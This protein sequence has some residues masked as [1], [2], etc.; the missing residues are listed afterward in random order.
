MAHRVLPA[1]G[2]AR[3]VREVLQD[4]SID[5]LHRQR[6]AGR[7]F[8]GHV[9]EQ[10]EGER[11]LGL[12]GVSGV[13]RGRGDDGGAVVALDV[14]ERAGAGLGLGAA[15]REVLEQVLVEPVE[16]GELFVS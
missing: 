3:E 13:R 9:Y 16:V 5:V 2:G 15:Q 4:P 14:E 10:G 7:L 6:L 8:D 11:R 1:S 12:D